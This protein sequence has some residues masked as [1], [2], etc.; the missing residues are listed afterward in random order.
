MKNV[1]KLGR[2]FKFRNRPGCRAQA[3]PSE[4]A[5]APAIGALEPGQPL[6]ERTRRVEKL[7]WHWQPALQWG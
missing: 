2:R 7:D 5:P 6:A 3:A 4:Q 1:E